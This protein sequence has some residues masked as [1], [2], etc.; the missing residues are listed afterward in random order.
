MAFVDSQPKEALLAFDSFLRVSLDFQGVC[1]LAP[2]SRPGR[3]FAP[4][5]LQ[6]HFCLSQMC[7]CRPSLLIKSHHILS[8]WPS[9]SPCLQASG[10]RLQ[11]LT[12]KSELCLTNFTC[13]PL[14]KFLPSVLNIIQQFSSSTY[15]IPSCAKHHAPSAPVRSSVMCSWCAVSLAPTAS[16]YSFSAC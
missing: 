9:P 11:H 14:L 16:S 10:F 5:A 15:K 8:R 4:P 6:L 7:V 2:C 12:L 3:R 1:E 13:L